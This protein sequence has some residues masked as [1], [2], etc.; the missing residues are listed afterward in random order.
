MRA[1]AS[2]GE[3]TASTVQPNP[4]LGVG[5]LL[6]VSLSVLLSV[7]LSVLLSVSLSVLL[8]V[9]RRSLERGRQS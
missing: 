6:S 9:S 1:V 5:G 4:N 8:S 7:S 2:C 3:L